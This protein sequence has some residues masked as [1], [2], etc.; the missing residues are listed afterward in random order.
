MDIT[1]L[2]G[3]KMKN[4]YGFLDKSFS[5]Y[6]FYLAMTGLVSLGMWACGTD[7]NEPEATLKIETPANGST[8]VGPNVK[9]KVST[10]N[11]TF[12]GAPVGKVSAAQAAVTGGHVH[13]FLDKPAGLDANAISN[14]TK[15]DTTTLS[16]TTAGVHYIIVEG[17]DGNHVDVESMH[18]SVQFTVTLP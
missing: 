9:L 14:L 7:S 18:D 4:R 16:I 8:V 5:K 11:F 17:A 2:K 12:S 6:A 15:Y 10:T 13:I 1:N 3:I